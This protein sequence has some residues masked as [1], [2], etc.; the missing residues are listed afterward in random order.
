M[1]NSLLT[2]RLHPNAPLGTQNRMSPTMALVWKQLADLTQSF[3]V[4]SA[5][6]LV[7][8]LLAAWLM[9][10]TEV[11]RVS[12]ATLALFSCGFALVACF[13]SFVTEYESRTRDFLGNLPVSSLH[14]GAVK[15]LSAA[16]AV[17]VFFGLQV[18]ARLMVLWFLRTFFD[19]S[20][21]GT[22]FQWT[23]EHYFVAL[24]VNAVFVSC[25]IC[26]SFWS[27]SWMSVVC[28]LPLA[29]LL[30]AACI[31]YGVFPE[32]MRNPTAESWG[33]PRVSKV[34]L[35]L[36]LVGAVSIP[37]FWLRRRPLNWK[38]TVSDTPLDHHEE[39]FFWVSLPGKLG[40]PTPAWLEMPGRD[41][42]PA[43][44]WQS[45][46]QQGML[47]FLA[48]LAV[49]VMA[50]LFSLVI[51]MNNVNRI[52]TANQLNGQVSQAM[53][54]GLVF[55]MSISGFGFGWG[56]LYRDKLNSN[57][58][59]FQQHKEYGRTLLLARVL[60]PSVLLLITLAVGSG[61][62]YLYTGHEVSIWPALLSGLG[63]FLATLMWSM[64]LRSFVYT[65]GI[66]LV[67]SLTING[68]IGAWLTHGEFEYGWVMVLPFV[69]LATCF[70]YAP[71]WLS[72]RRTVGWMVWFTFVSMI[73]FAVPLWK[74]TLWLLGMEP[75]W[76]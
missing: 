52:F 59:F 33:Y 21:W 68:F 73:T 36:A 37:L 65:L 72:G 63:A 25:L 3:V 41:R 26:C 54:M 12:L 9:R 29:W 48:L 4:L 10:E 31:S 30:C 50:C 16:S 19:Q 20:I 57:F 38:R 5:A 69:W 1:S 53:Q 24:M 62:I 64:A 71:T 55:V 76:R 32:S 8:L 51:E 56:A 13:T 39:D 28:A 23:T 7:V 14:V 66:G 18:L 34:L 49:G 6:S 46:R 11:Y 70:A 15:Q 40:I 61:V 2:P 47:P 45:V 35:A 17:A 43:L 42:F 75:F 44:C 27:T 67:L 60:F 22:E 58:N 74:M